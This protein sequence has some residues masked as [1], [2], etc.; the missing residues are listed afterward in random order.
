MHVRVP[1]Y[2][3]RNNEAKVRGTQWRCG[4]REIRN[5]IAKWRGGCAEEGCVCVCVFVCP[6]RRV[7]CCR[8]CPHTC[9][10]RAAKE[11]E[12]VRET[13]SPSTSLPRRLSGSLTDLQ[14]HLIEEMGSTTA[15]GAALKEGEGLP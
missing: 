3:C 10:R 11:A 6:Q 13:L 14:I 15:L 4:A 9:P 1:V 12:A 5:K 8:L 2:A 7:A